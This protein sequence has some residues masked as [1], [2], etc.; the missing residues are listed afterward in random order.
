MVAPIAHYGSRLV[1]QRRYLIEKDNAKP[2]VWIRCD[3]KQGGIFA[4]EFVVRD[5]Q[6]HGTTT[7]TWNMVTH[8]QV[9]FFLHPFLTACTI[10]V[11]LIDLTNL[12]G[13]KMLNIIG[14]RFF[15][16]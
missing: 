14:I 4:S 11:L 16:N 2:C 10:S 13:I 15:L 3:A 12:V 9:Y 5:C 1:S 7:D 6:S 8:S